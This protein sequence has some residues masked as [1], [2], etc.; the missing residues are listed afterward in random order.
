[1]GLSRGIRSNP[2]AYEE[3]KNHSCLNGASLIRC[4]PCVDTS[5]ICAYSP[6]VP[7]NAFASS[8]KHDRTELYEDLSATYLEK[9]SNSRDFTRDLTSQFEQRLDFQISAV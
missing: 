5:I 8:E 6:S 3:N 1:M 7:E 2:V 4:C 9:D